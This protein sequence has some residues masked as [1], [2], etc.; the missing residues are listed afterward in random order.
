MIWKGLGYILPKGGFDGPRSFHRGR[1]GVLR[2]RLCRRTFSVEGRFAS[3]R[4]G[5][6]FY[7]LLRKMG[8]W[9]GWK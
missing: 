4:T 7:G 1:R 5:G 9:A 8:I 6:C 3:E 2:L